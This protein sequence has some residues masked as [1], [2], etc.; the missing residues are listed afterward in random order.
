MPNASTPGGTLKTRLARRGIR[1]TERH[2]IRC[3]FD[4]L[5]D[6]QTVLDPDGIE[7][8]DLDAAIAEAQRAVAEMQQEVNFGTHLG[9]GAYLRVRISMECLLCKIPLGE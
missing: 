6:C 3:H 1:R 2:R 5:S 7:V 4:V 8:S 9:P